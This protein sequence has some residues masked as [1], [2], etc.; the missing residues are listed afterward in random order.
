M[1]HSKEAH[2]KMN[3]L[4]NFHK[5]HWE[6]DAGETATADGKYTSGEMDNPEHLKKSVNELAGYVKRNK[7]SY[8]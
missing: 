6:K 3:G 1:A 2:A 5:D 4:G 8:P 7:M